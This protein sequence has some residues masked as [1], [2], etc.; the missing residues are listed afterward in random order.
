[1]NA[2]SQIPTVITF[3]ELLMR[4]NTVGHERFLQANELQASYTGGEANVAVALSQWDVPTR[5]VSCV[6]DHEM[7]T[8]CLNHFRK[9]GVETQHV[10]RGG[11]RLG[12]LFVETGASQRNSKVIYDRQHSSFR[13]IQVR[14]IDWDGAFADAGWFHFTGTAPAVSEETRVVLRH[15]IS[16]AKERG[17]PVSMDCSYRSA[18]W[19]IEEARNVLSSLL[20][21]VDV[22][23]GSESDASTFF[24]VHE[25]GDAC[26]VALRERYNL[27]CVAFTERETFSTGM[28][29]YCG[30]ISM[31]AGKATSQSYDIHV[32]DRIGAGDAFAAGVI[33]G[34][35]LDHSPKEIADFSVA[36]AV[37]AH[38]LPG[39]FLLATA[40]E[41]EAVMN[42]TNHSKGWR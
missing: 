19:S 28:N 32:I 20:E 8:A 18:L 35:L 27:S 3:G 16:I 9:Y 33:R 37:L 13:Q 23:M 24:D 36:A 15:A 7:G 26:M 34:F 11:D 40:A 6:P 21:D 4:L 12:I 29:R 38:S 39:D 41:V 10:A 31:N 30:S 5:I 1:M 25:T 14:D 2:M 22:F 42:N 17:I